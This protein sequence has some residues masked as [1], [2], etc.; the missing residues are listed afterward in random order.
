VFQLIWDWIAG[1]VVD[2]E[3]LIR[4]P[5][6][7]PYR[8]R[9]HQAYVVWDHRGR[10][11]RQAGHGLQRV[12]GNGFGCTLLRSELFRSTRFVEDTDCDRDFY[13]QLNRTHLAAKVDWDCACGHAEILTESNRTL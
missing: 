7:A 6:A 3:Y 2:P 13:R 1:F 9:F 4:M 8:S 10:N 11:V 5:V 12:G